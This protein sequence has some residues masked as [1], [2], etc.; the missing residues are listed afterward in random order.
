MLT[1]IEPNGFIVEAVLALAV[2]AVA[3]TAFKCFEIKIYI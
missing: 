3:I 1:S 2:V